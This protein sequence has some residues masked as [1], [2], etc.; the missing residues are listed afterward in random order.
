MNIS[1]AE[2]AAEFEGPASQP[3]LGTRQF[4]TK[5]LDWT[6]PV[7]RMDILS[8]VTRNRVSPCDSTVKTRPSLVSPLFPP[9]A[10]VSD[11][12]REAISCRPHA[13]RII[14]R[15]GI[16]FRCSRNSLR[17]HHRQRERKRERY[18]STA[19]DSKIIREMKRSDENER[20]VLFQGLFLLFFFFLFKGK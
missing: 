9:P 8:R 7:Q 4:A 15:G 10:L 20:R 14:S 5:S 18:L 3:P 17:N 1:P 12:S 13:Y 2:R 11:V 19:E 16:F 6:I